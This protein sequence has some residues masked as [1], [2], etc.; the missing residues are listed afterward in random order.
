M[1]KIVLSIVLTLTVVSFVNS[2]ED[3]NRNLEVKQDF[4]YIKNSDLRIR[5]ENKLRKVDQINKPLSI[6]N[7]ARTLENS[8]IE[9]SNKEKYNDYINRIRFY[10]DKGKVSESKI[11]LKN[12]LIYLES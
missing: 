4:Y 10:L 6:L 5:L 2:Q 12:M 3:I 8:F 9:L 1:R 7:N 11:L